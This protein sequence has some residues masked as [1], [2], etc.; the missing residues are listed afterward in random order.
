MIARSHRDLHAVRRSVEGIK[1]LS[2]RVVGVG[3][4]GVGL[5]GI[6]AW[7]P[8]VGAVYTVVT[9]GLLMMHAVRAR[10]SAGTLLHMASVL[11]ADSL[12]DLIPVPVAPAVVDMLFTGQKWA[13]NALLK[14]MDETVYYEGTRAE[15]EADPEFREHLD[16]L[17]DARGPRRRIVYLE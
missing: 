10:A 17:P 9:G 3:P 1:K 12:T 2:D 13:A 14:H 11:I 5:D 8:G 4:F 16:E 15:G 7:I 6:T